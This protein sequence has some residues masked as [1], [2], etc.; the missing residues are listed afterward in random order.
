MV[1]NRI[2]PTLIVGLVGAVI[3]SFL[4][5]VY[6]GTHFGGATGPDRTPPAIAAVPSMARAKWRRVIG[7]NRFAAPWPPFP[8]EDIS[9]L[10]FLMARLRR[11]AGFSGG[12]LPRTGMS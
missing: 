6:A 11:E 1:K 9:A 7:H 4:M 5:M 2:L 12:T 3:G 8:L 10:P